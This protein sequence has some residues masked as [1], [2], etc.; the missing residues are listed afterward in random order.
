M[1][2]TIPS[3]ASFTLGLDGMTGP[4][5]KAP[6]GASPAPRHLS[7]R[8]ASVDVNPSSATKFYSAPAYLTI[9]KSLK[10]ISVVSGEIN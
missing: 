1:T 3:N 2:P 7:A 5:M 9:K 10:K 6:V 4:A 8:V